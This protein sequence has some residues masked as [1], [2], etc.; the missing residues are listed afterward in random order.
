MK[1]F[2]ALI[3]FLTVGLPIVHAESEQINYRVEYTL[4][5]IH[6]TAAHGV[7]T[8]DTNGSI[9]TGTLNGHSIPWG[10]RLYTVSDTLKMQIANPVRNDGTPH[11]NITYRNGWYSKPKVDE[12]KDK[13]YDPL[14]PANYKTIL[15]AGQLNASN[16]TMEA[17][18]ITS[19]MLGLFHLF[20]SYDFST[21]KP[22]YTM[23]IPMNLPNNTVQHVYVTYL[24]PSSYNLNGTDV[25]TYK[26]RFEYTYHGARSN[27]PV[28]CQLDPESRIP[29]LLYADLEIG[30][31]ELIYEPSTA[32]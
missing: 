16:A 19:D 15:G 17:V 27:Y 1:K 28:Y 25:K 21:V 5:P 22:G 13:T 11:Q 32:N 4:G 18:T 9:F 12:I 29:L 26:L 14:N 2:L 8:L 23:N 20:K 10:G 30:K 31:M 3:A 6:K 7:V 24:G